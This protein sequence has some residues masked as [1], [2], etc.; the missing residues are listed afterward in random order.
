MTKKGKAGHT[1]LSKAKTAAIKKIIM[2]AI[3]NDS[4]AEATYALDVVRKIWCRAIGT[5]SKGQ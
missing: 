3:K 5:G 4:K 2:D 1:P